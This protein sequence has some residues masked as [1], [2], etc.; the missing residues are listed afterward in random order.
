M[1]YVD[2]R[3][4]AKHFGYKSHHSLRRLAQRGELPGAVKAGNRWRVHL[5]TLEKAWGVKKG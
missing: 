3:Y 2:L 1:E 5:E 4:V